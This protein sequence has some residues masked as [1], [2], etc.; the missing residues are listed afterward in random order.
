MLKK[1]INRASNY[2][3]ELVYSFS[4]I[5]RPIVR[6]SSS[7]IVAAYVIPEKFG[8]IQ[9][10]ALIATYFTFL[11]LGV[12]RGLNRNIAFYKA[13]NRPEKVQDMVNSSFWVSKVVGVVGLCAGLLVLLYFW[14]NDYDLIYLLSA[15]SLSVL[16]FFTPQNMHFDTTFRSGREFKSLGVILI[17]QNTIFGL[18]NALTIFFGYFG[19]IAADVINSVCGYFLRERRQPIR[20]SGPPKRKEA[21]E[22][23]KVGLP[24]LVGG[25]LLSLF[26]V[27]DQSLIATRLGNEELGFYTISKLILLAIPVIPVTLSTLLYPRASAQYGR[28]KSNRGLRS[29]YYKALFFNFIVVAPLCVILYFVLPVVVEGYLPKYLPGLEAARI[30]LLTCMTFI[31]IGPSIIIGV[32]RRNTPYIIFTGVVLL[33]FW[34]VG[35]YVTQNDGTIE[36]IAYLRFGFSMLL[37]VFSLLYSYYLTTLRDYRE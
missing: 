7:F 31:S 5:F 16:L 25:Y 20:A 35:I 9:S 26:N 33:S 1:L 36:S 24:L 37:S 8:I 6:L 30:N 18:A 34:I 11:N 3:G 12:F 2:K 32:V 19:K 22:L 28:T 10:V 27:T 21:V 17:I 29:F 23:S 13:Q 14:L 4:S 15:F